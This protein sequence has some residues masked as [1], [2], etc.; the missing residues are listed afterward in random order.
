VRVEVFDENIQFSK[1]LTSIKGPI[2]RD[3]GGDN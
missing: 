3:A 2:N 1:R